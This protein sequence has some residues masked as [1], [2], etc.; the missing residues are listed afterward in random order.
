MDRKWSAHLDYYEE[1][2]IVRWHD[3]KVE[4]PVSLFGE[5]TMLDVLRPEWQEIIDSKQS[6]D[7]DGQPRD[8]WIGD[9][10]VSVHPGQKGGGKRAVFKYRIQVGNAWIFLSDR[11]EGEGASAA[12]PS[13]IIEIKGR[14][15]V[16]DGVDP[17][18]KRCRAVLKHLG[19]EIVELRRS[20]VDACVDMPGLSMGGCHELYRAGLF[21]TPSEDDSVHR[22]A[23]KI[24]GIY[25]GSGKG[26]AKVKLYDKTYEV[27]HK[28]KNDPEY[29]AAMYSRWGGTCEAATR[30]E[31]MTR[32]AFWR[33]AEKGDERLQD[34]DAEPSRLVGC[35]LRRVMLGR[36]A[37][38]DIE[39]S[40][41]SLIRIAEWVDRDKRRYGPDHQI[42]TDILA[43]I[44]DAFALVAI[45][46]CPEPSV[47][48]AAKAAVQAIARAATIEGVELHTEEQALGLLQRIFGRVFGFGGVEA[49]LE[50]RQT[51]IARELGRLADLRV[52]FEAID[53][54]DPF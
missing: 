14:G 4:K 1:S 42:W 51:R 38:K 47:E 10:L 26:A 29:Q 34:V 48:K 30:L 5:T 31:V 2:L 15:C 32:R 7:D 23:G 49:E 9:E 25:F 33:D 8:I 44:P 54:V 53:G 43:V 37:E 52:S 39:R 36:P 20:R 41:R 40:T 16:V 18:W 50:K 19:A 11:E 22:T 6:A 3:R 24:T 12:N 46:D 17:L 27:E 35:L 28:R 45:K 21:V 13:A